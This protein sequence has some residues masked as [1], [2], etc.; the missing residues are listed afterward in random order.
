MCMLHSP[1]LDVLPFDSSVQM[2]ISFVSDPYVVD[3][4][5]F[6]LPKW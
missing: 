4:I 6:M 2:K 5:L 3:Y 1:E